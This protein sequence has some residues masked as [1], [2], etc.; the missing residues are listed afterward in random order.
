VQIVQKPSEQ[1]HVESE[2]RFAQQELWH[3]SRKVIEGVVQSLGSQV[4]LD[5]TCLVGWLNR[6]CGLS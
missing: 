6:I 5:A 3:D 2:V 1:V 4:S